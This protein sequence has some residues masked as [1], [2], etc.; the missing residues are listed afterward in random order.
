MTKA[1]QTDKEERV[2][3]HTTPLVREKSNQKRS[4]SKR[5]MTWAAPKANPLLPDGIDDGHYGPSSSERNA[6]V[7]RGPGF[8]ERTSRAKVIIKSPGVRA[9]SGNSKGSCR[10]NSSLCAVVVAVNYRVGM[11]P[12]AGTGYLVR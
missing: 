4:V 9:Q 11:T 2:R 3:V 8:S 6:W 12:V 1:V 10:D 7:S 5:T